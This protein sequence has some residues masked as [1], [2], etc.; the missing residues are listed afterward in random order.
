MNI[1]KD[2]A[3]VRAH[4]KKIKVWTQDEQTMTEWDNSLQG[5][6]DMRSFGDTKVNRSI[7]A[8]YVKHLMSFSK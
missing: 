5:L 3:R 4:G 2:I 8:G 1:T 6:L 7:V